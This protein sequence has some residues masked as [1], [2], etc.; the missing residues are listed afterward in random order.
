M[1]RFEVFRPATCVTSCKRNCMEPIQA[2][3]LGH[4][5]LVTYFPGWPDQGLAFDVALFA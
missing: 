1:R 5:I 4:L 3:V 2:I